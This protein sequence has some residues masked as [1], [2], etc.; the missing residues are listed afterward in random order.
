MKS[1]YNRMKKEDKAE[2]KR[3]LAEEKAAEKAF[4]QELKEG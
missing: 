1:T 3:I 4:H 2:K